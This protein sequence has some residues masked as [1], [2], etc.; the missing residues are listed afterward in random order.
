MRES[1]YAPYT[2]MP[3][4][5]LDRNA[6]QAGENVGRKLVVG[7]GD[8]DEV[9]KKIIDYLQEEKLG[10]ATAASKPDES[11]QS[12]YEIQVFTVNESAF[13]AGMPFVN[14]AL[15]HF[16]RG[17]IRGAYVAFMETENIEVKETNCWGLG[18]TKCVFE[19]RV[20]PM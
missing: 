5:Q 13:A 14:R 1:V 4:F 10:I 17:V 12:H 18:D 3:E 2:L 9:N 19:M 20:T 16:I 8:K 11:G 6:V 7:A 15:C